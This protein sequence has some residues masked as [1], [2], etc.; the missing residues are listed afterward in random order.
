MTTRLV[1]EREST[2][3][4]VRCRPGPRGLHRPVHTPSYSF[5]TE[6]SAEGLQQDVLYEQ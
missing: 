2:C 6:S 3:T 5:I 4:S 1:L